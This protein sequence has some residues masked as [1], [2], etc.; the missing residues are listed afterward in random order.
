M[1]IQRTALDAFVAK[2]SFVDAGYDVVPVQHK[3]YNAHMRRIA[4]HLNNEK[5]CVTTSFRPQTPLVNIGYAIRVS[6]ITRLVDV[7]V[8]S[9]QSS[10]NIVFLG[11][12]LDAAGLWSLGLS[13]LT[14]V[15]ELDNPA[16]TDVKRSIYDKCELSL[17]NRIVPIGVDL[18]NL[19][20]LTT[21][22][23]NAKVDFSVP[24]LVVSELVLS[25]LDNVGELLRFFSEK[26]GSKFVI[27]EPFLP[28]IKLVDSAFSTSNK[29]KRFADVYVDRF[30]QKTELLGGLGESLVEV[31]EFLGNECGLVNCEV[32]RASL[33][34]PLMKTKEMFDEHAA[35]GL[36]LRNY[37]VATNINNNNSEIV[38]RVRVRQVTAGDES[39]CRELFFGVY[40]DLAKRYKSIAKMLKNASDMDNICKHYAADKYAT[41]SRKNFFVAIGSDGR[42][43]GCIGVLFCDFRKCYEINRLFVDTAARNTGIGRALLSRVETFAKKE[44]FLVAITPVLLTSAQAFYDKNGFE[45]DK[46]FNFPQN[47]EVPLSVFHKLVK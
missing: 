31:S 17:K 18:Q 7:F 32:S 37:F 10:H 27:F 21:Q 36:Y 24:T 30:R 26:K 35:L 1:N 47:F 34:A 16:Y 38:V 14:T 13:P 46:L 20:D 11:C 5:C 33:G 8:K 22:L 2:L 25:Y 4:N 12:G 28:R 19:P 41:D 3:L 40:S 9:C 6:I 39:A 43:I 45:K 42:V 29:Y 15:Y 44:S 23:T